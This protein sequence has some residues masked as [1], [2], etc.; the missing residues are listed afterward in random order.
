MSFSLGR[1]GD[2]KRPVDAHARPDAVGFH[3]GNWRDFL[4]RHERAAAKV[5]Q[6]GRA[7]VLE[8]VPYLL[9][10][11]ADPRDFRNAWAHC[12][13]GG[14]GPGPNGRRYRDYEEHDIWNLARAIGP[15]ILTDQYCPG[16]EWKMQIP[17]GHGRGERT[18]SIQD[19]EDRAVGRMFV[20]IL[21]PLLD[22]F[23]DDLSFGSRPGRNRLHA[24]AAAEHLAVEQGRWVWV[25]ADVKNAFDRVPLSRLLDIVR[26]HFP[27]DE[28]VRAIRRIIDRG[29][30]R[31]L[32]QG[33]PLSPLMMNT[34]RDHVLDQKWRRRMADIPL[35]VHVDDILLMCRTIEEAHHAWSVLEEI[36]TPA[37]LSLKGSPETEVQDLA[38]GD[39]AEW[40]GFAV[41]KGQE[42][43]EVRIA[44]EAW[45]K[46]AQRLALAHGEPGAPGRANDILRGWIDQQGPS[47]L[48]EDQDQ[49]L[50]RIASEAQ[51]RAFDEVPPQPD[52]LGRWQ[53]AHARW[54][55]LRKG[56]SERGGAK[57]GGGSARHAGF[58]AEPG[59]GDGAPAG[60]PSP[61]HSSCERVVLYTDGC[62]LARS[63]AG[64]WAYM[65]HREDGRQKSAASGGLQRTTSNRAELIAAIKGLERMP[66]GTRVVLVSDATYVVQ[67]INERLDLWRARGW[68]AGSAR[69]RRPLQNADLWQ[70]LDALVGRLHV[71]GRH[72][73]GHAGHREN[74]L[75]D[76]LAREQALQVKSSGGHGRQPA[77]VVRKHQ[78]GKSNNETT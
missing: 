65:L 70:R 22:P 46:L 15:A 28:L 30:K 17:K 18:L 67:G 31:G 8:M 11:A 53:R 13:Q 57:G 12:S 71:K 63:R 60:A 20:Q 45:E 72:V 7:G 58:P 59:R 48:H 10:W 43:L 6:R 49:V 55:R 54:C 41:R 14:Q 68:R 42:G 23:F 47:F 25:I 78:H 66:P 38:T 33:S 74:E 76:R 9:R 62:C 5:V 75:C 29:C 51:R 73:Y 61:L 27:D 69:H 56:A 32:R 34:Y 64:G 40:L 52:L 24:L 36:L 4:R 16:P 26:R 35:L 21:Q 3:E 19:I 77:M 1:W 37:G 50:T 39:T 2:S 44:S